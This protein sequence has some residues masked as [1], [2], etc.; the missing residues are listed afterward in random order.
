MSK[1]KKSAEEA[2]LSGDTDAPAGTVVLDEAIASLF[3]EY[4]AGFNDFDADALADCFALPATIWQLDKGYVFDDVDDILENIDALLDALEQEH[5]T[6]SDYEVVSCFIS[7]TSALVT[8]N[9]VQQTED[10]DSVF[11]FTCHYHLIFDGDDWAIAM[12]VN[13]QQQ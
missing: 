10:G 6:H 11:E 7:G 5:V 13:E 2:G 9:W 3:D 12:L 4:A 8:L 1:Q